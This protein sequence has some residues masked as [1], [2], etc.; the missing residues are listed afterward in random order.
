MDATKE[1]YIRGCNTQEKREIA[2][3]TKM[4]TLYA[5]LTL[6]KH[7]GITPENTFL[8]VLPT[9]VT[10]TLANLIPNEHISIIDLY[11]GMM[12]PS[13]NDA[14]MAL[15]NWGGALINTNPE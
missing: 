14:A 1:S 3:I 12:L 9:V 8:E 11:Y 2:S 5:C 7:F 10:G 6:N 13:G 4:Y 15:A